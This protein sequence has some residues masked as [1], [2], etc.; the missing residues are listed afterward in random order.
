MN[1]VKTRTHVLNTKSGG[2]KKKRKYKHRV[3][4][5][6]LTVETGTTTTTI[7]PIRTAAISN[8]RAI[9]FKWRLKQLVDDDEDDPMIDK[10]NRSPIRAPTTLLANKDFY[11][12][13]HFNA[14][15]VIWC[16]YYTQTQHKDGTSNHN[17]HNR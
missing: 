15:N 6:R 3:L 8:I 17:R 7:T 9:S 10:Y 16:N 11:R 14:T 4:C 1:Q 5:T 13:Q 2:R 12:F